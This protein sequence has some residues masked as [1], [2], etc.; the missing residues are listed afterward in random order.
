M[1]IDRR[2]GFAIVVDES[3]YRLARFK[4]TYRF[5]FEVLDRAGHV[6]DSFSCESY[7]ERYDFYSTHDDGIDYN[8]VHVVQV[9][10]RMEQM[11]DL[12]CASLRPLPDF[13]R[14]G[15]GARAAMAG[16][17]SEVDF[18]DYQYDLTLASNFGC[19]Y[20][21]F[22]VTGSMAEAQA[23]IVGSI[24]SE[25]VR[26]VSQAEVASSVAH[27]PGLDR[28]SRSLLQRI[29]S[30]IARVAAFPLGSLK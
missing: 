30:L 4:Q 18:D 9:G 12:S 21:E 20:R 16:Y 5:D 24:P 7:D 11:L 25:A 19:F 26:A 1:Q 27:E 17:A 28:H 8:V 10:D 3:G 29:R 23:M 13:K 6:I 15:D 22:V 2:A 14:L